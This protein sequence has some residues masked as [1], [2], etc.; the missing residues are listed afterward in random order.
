[1]LA[2]PNPNPQSPCLEVAGQTMTTSKTPLRSNARRLLTPSFLTL[3]F[4]DNFASQF[5]RQVLYFR[6][7]WRYGPCAMASHRHSSPEPEAALARDI[8]A[9]HNQIRA[10]RP[11]AAAGLVRS[12]G[13]PRSGVGHPSAPGASSSTTAR[14]PPSAKI[15][16]RSPAGT[17]LPVRR[18]WRS[19][20]PKPAI[21]A[22]HQHLLG[23]LR[24]LHP[25]HLARHS[26][27]GLR[28]RPRCPP[29]KSGSAIT[30]R[31]AIG[32]ASVLI[33]LESR[34]PQCNSARRFHLD[35][36]HQ[37]NLGENSM[38]RP[39]LQRVVKWHC[40]HMDRRGLI[41]PQLF[42]CANQTGERIRR[43]A[44]FMPAIQTEIMHIKTIVHLHQPG[45]LP[46][47]FK[48]QRDSPPEHCVRQFFPKS[49]LP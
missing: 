20:R 24:P 46:D 6:R 18:C 19:G 39:G 14:I 45:A 38:Q 27:G 34:H 2:T 32:S 42:Q 29:R 13:R 40:N 47:V 33:E 28:R 5:R 49:R 23:R 22:T 9:A 36:P 16:L 48:M 17:A 25:A 26:R 4:R 3:S 10:Q 35:R 8:S 7:S 21:T 31:R 30:I 15:S 12:A 37:R 44:D 41:M 43:A 1:M 11:R